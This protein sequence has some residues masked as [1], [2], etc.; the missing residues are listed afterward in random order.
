MPSVVLET[1]RLRLRAFTEADIDDVFESVTDPVTRKW[2]PIPAP[3]R[4]YTRADAVTWCVDTAPA[5]RATGDGQQWAAVL[6]DTGA[7][8]GSFGLVRT[9]WRART[10]EVGYWVAPA[11]RG[12]GVASEAV[13]A[14]TRWVL[15]EQGFERLQLKAATANTASRRV[16]ERTGFVYEGTERNAAPL[17][18]GRT[19]LAVYSVIRSDLLG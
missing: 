19:D 10:T 14:I 7:F 2:V 5:M 13:T 12:R 1:D 15:L 6:K 11:A 9:D 17:H 8:A 18:H 4:P 3:G 16:A